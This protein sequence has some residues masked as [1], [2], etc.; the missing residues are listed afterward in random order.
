M[1]E[2]AA[3]SPVYR[4]ALEEFRTY[5]TIARAIIKLRM[6]MNMSQEE[7]AKAVATSSSAIARLESGQHKPS[8]ETLRRI[9]KAFN[10]D[11]VISFAKPSKRL[12]G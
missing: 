5:E 4:A 7:L 3:K 1:R 12:A 10:R 6:D 8:V 2:R 9:A 11:L